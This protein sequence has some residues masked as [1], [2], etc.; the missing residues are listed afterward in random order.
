MTY[1]LL[2]CDSAEFSVNSAYI[3]GAILAANM[4]IKPLAPTQWLTE[5]FAEISAEFEQQVTGQLN[6][7]YM[8]LKRNEYSALSLVHSAEQPSQL[9]DFA[10]GFMAVWHDIE[11]HWF[12]KSIPDGTLRMLQ[13]LLTTLSLAIDESQ[14]HEQMRS[15]GVEVFPSLVDLV[16]NLDLMINEVALAADEL[17]IG[18]KSQMI[19][20]YKGTGRNDP[21]PCASGKKFKQC[22]GQ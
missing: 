13:G 18:Q 8:L 6:H 5:L 9:A 14:T 3:E 11:P 7:Q 12:E 22:C 21:C 2:T 16:G 15:A 10:Q 20:P 1:Q 17:Q 4:S 19:N